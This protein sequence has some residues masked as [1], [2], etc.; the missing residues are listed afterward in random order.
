MS[1]ILIL[2]L[3]AIL[4]S[5]CANVSR[6]KKNSLVAHAEIIDGSR[7]PLYYKIWIDFK[8]PVDTQTRNFLLKLSL[9]SPPLALG[10]LR[11]EIV[12][13][14]L[15][16]FIPPPQ[17]PDAWKQKTKDYD[18]YAGGGFHIT[19]KDGNLLSVGI[20][21]HCSG[22]RKNPI[23]GTPNGQN[24]Y[25]LPITEQQIIEIFGSPDSINKVNEVRY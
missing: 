23:I 25:T 21:S 2:I 10:E 1:R 7:V 12:A 24:F 4:L 5:A 16:H 18:T 14:Y 22:G 6:F 20:C 3:F 8:N 17:W 15:P 9:N 13:H 19:F 11:P